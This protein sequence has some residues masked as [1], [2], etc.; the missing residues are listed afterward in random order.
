MTSIDELSPM[1]GAM[2]VIGLMAQQFHD[3]NLATFGH[4]LSVVGAKHP[5]RRPNPLAIGKY[6][7]NVDALNSNSC[8]S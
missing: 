4:N 2:D 8:L 1:G 6:G 5:K 7:S 3:V